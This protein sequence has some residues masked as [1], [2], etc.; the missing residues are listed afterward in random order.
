MKKEK[1]RQIE[2]VL[3]TSFEFAVYQKV[4]NTAMA[5][6]QS[7]WFINIEKA[8]SGWYLLKV[9]RLAYLK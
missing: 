7:G 8:E 9:Y 4:V 3:H 2:I 5:L 6:A 1:Q